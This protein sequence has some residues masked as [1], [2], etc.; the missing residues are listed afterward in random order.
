MKKITSHLNKISSTY[1]SNMHT[2]REKKHVSHPSKINLNVAHQLYKIASKPRIETHLELDWMSSSNKFRVPGA[3]EEVKPTSTHRQ[4]LRCA[5][6][7]VL[8]HTLGIFMCFEC[9]HSKVYIPSS[10]GRQSHILNFRH[11]SN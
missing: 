3:G 4:T 5:V 7:K 10:S 2:Q 9:Y 11:C 1:I 6:L 8:H